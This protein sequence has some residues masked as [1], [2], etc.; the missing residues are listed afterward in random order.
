MAV[1]VPHVNELVAEQQE[2]KRLERLGRR[3][4]VPMPNT[5]DELHAYVV[6]GDVRKLRTW[7]AA[8]YPATYSE[9]F[10]PVHT[11]PAGQGEA[12][13][14]LEAL[15]AQCRFPSLYATEYVDVERVINEAAGP[16]WAWCY[17]RAWAD[18]VIREKDQGRATRSD[19][20]N[21]INVLKPLE[22]VALK[23]AQTELKPFH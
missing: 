12:L 10:G 23:Q 9:T 5:I 8:N 15:Y 2:K 20:R 19:L 4:A 11:F 22:P 6:S 13:R 3:P 1:T 17:A 16:L 14:L 18:H 7:M 21:A